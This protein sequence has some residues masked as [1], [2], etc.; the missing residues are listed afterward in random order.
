MTRSS[1]VH[2][3]AG[4]VATSTLLLSGLLS[5][6]GGEE[7]GPQAGDRSLSVQ[8]S[9]APAPSR[10]SAAPKGASASQTPDSASGTASAPAR[11]S[12]R[13]RSVPVDDA[14]GDLPPGDPG[15]GAPSVPD[16]GV[17]EQGRD[18]AE[19]ARTA[20]PDGAMLDVASVSGVLGG[21][22]QRSAAAPL[23]CLAGGERVARRSAAYASDDGRLLQ[24]VGTHRSVAAADQAVDRAARRLAACNWTEASDPRLGSA[25]TAASSA[26]G[27]R[28]AVV[29]SAEGVTVTLVG[30]EA[31]TVRRSRWS[32]LL[33]LALGNSCAAAPDGC[34]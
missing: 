22:W 11:P 18:H 27:T 10:A 24:T 12:S 14:P 23:R 7:T 6:C 25:S 17:P 3:A 30:T 28:T 19:P 4:L 15:T 1:S 32:S 5:A 16:P 13:P 8:P 33:D 21:R 29:I 2:R 20:V 9:A 26:S 31:V 34:H